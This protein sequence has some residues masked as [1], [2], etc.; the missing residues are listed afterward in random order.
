MQYDEVLN[1]LY[2]QILYL[3][4]HHRYTNFPFPRTLVSFESALNRLRDFIE[5]KENFNFI[6]HRLGDFLHY[7]KNLNETQY[8]PTYKS[9]IDLMKQGFTESGLNALELDLRMGDGGEVYVT[10]DELKPNLHPDSLNYLKNNTFYKF[11]NNFIENKF[12]E[13]NKLFIELKVSPKIIDIESFSFFPDMLK[14]S[15]KKLI[16][17]I[18]ILL[19]KA[20]LPYLSEREAIKKSISFVS[21]SKRSLEYAYEYSNDSYEYFLIVSTNQFIKKELSPLFYYKPFDENQISEIKA[22]EWL[23]GIWFDPFHIDNAFDTFSEINSNRNNKLRYYISTYGMDFDELLN[24]LKNSFRNKKLP[25]SGIIF[26][27]L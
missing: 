4:N 24:K 3:G 13:K 6:G 23:T 19:E 17:N 9:T 15:E 16:E 2:S 1:F 11:I 25:V 10:H 14:S 21:F 18:F 7:P 22:A 12:Y 8:I 5:P 27:V 20:L 26:D